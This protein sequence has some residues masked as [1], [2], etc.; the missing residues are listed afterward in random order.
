MAV[1]IT[2]KEMVQALEEAIEAFVGE[3]P[4]HDDFTIMGLRYSGV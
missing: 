2:M 4:Q 1:S 3:A